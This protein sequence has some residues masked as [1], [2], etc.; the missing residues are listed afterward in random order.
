MR[1]ETGC[2]IVSLFI[3]CAA[4]G[5]ETIYHGGWIDLNKNGMLDPYEDSNRSV[6]DRINDLLARMTLDEKTCQMATIYGFSR[7]LKTARPAEEWKSRVWKD[8]AANIDEHANGV[9]NKD[10]FIDFV[11]HGELINEVQ[12]WFI[13]NTRLGIPVDFSNEGIR[14][15]C[16][17]Y[18]CN[19]PCQLG[20]GA[21]W[22][23]DL[24]RRIGEITGKEAKALGYSNIY[25]PILD[26]VR[27]PRWGRTIE[28]YGESPFLVG[29]MGKAQVLGLQSQGVGS[30]VKHFAAY[31]A[32]HGGRDAQCR[33]DP[34]IPFRDMQEILLEPFRKVFMEASPKGTM[35]SYNTYDGIPV[36]GSHYFLTELLRKEYG[37]KGYVV[38]DSGAVSRLFEQHKVAETWEDAIALAVNAGLNV[39]TN[40]KEMEDFVLPLRMAIK[41]EKISEET[42]N[43]RVADVLRVKF[44]LGLFD[45][46]F[47]DAQK[48]PEKIHTEASEAVTREAA[49]KSIVLLKN[50]DNVLPLDRKKIKTILVAG[51]G[52][53]DIEPMIC[54]YGPALS[55]VIT[56]LTGIKAL[57]ENRIDVLYSQGADFADARFPKSDVLPEPPNDAEQKMLDDAVAKAKQADV[58]VAVVGDNGRTVGESHSRTDLRLPGHQ[59]LLVQELVKTGK[60]VI[61]VLMIGRSAAINWI[62]QNVP[63]ILVCW[64]GGEKTGVA[65]AEALFGEINPGGKLPITFP[66]TVGQL[67]LAVPHRNGAWAGQSG[68]NDVNGWG[69]TRVIDPLYPFGFGLSYT[70]FEYSDLNISPEKPTANDPVTVTCRIKNTG[71]C[72]GDEVVQLYITDAVA[73]VTPFEQ[74]LRGFERVA[75]KAGETKTVQFTLTPK[76]DLKMLNQENQWVVEPGRFEV[77][78]GTSSD[79]NGIRLKGSFVM[80]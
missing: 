66:R 70:T 54:R 59:E 8:G 78:V 5:G 25:S 42:I 52:A 32:P 57:A 12:R 6:D 44:E 43:S 79:P 14:G 28:C 9:K 56:P 74:V 34:Q 37:F 24:V 31:S 20:V 45:H 21:T 13:E 22:D 46:P 11:K 77:K 18:A 64:H 39:R 49:R 75:L 27:D 17:P 76:R 2:Q 40:F 29:E 71:T 50:R 33:T 36:T 55:D 53:D 35:S 69:S 47:V 19:F 38:S 41:K 4:A 51:P 67:P 72:D 26:T 65:V 16:H 15:V 61:V 23:L 30:T 48:A 60:P 58:I 73:S 7:V 1:K 3:A 80:E 68:K 62:D 10:E 63:G